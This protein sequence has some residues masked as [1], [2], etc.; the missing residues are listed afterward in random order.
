MKRQPERVLEARELTARNAI[1]LED[2]MRGDE[3]GVRRLAFFL[4]AEIGSLAF[5]STL[6][7]PVK[8][9]MRQLRAELRDLKH[10]MDGRATALPKPKK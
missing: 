7:E 1:G 4:E 3:E 6:P 9:R 10:F 8:D 5:F 2:A